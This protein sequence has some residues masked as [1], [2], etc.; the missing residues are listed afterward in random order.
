[1]ATDLEKLQNQFPSWRFGS[2]WASVAT[3][4]DARRLYAAKDTILITAWTAGELAVS[5]RREE[6]DAT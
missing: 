2:V 4:P 1:M 6:A 5:I 3:G